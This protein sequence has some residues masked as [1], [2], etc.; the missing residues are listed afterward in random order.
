[1]QLRQV[2]QKL[3][4][5]NVVGPVGREVNGISYDIRAVQPGCL[6]VAVARDKEDGHDCIDEA[7]AR[8]AVAIICEKKWQYQTAGD[9]S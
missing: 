8:G 1:M 6:F 7:I 5:A 9:Q 3:G 4:I 2:I